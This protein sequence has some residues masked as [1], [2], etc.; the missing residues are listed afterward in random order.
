MNDLE[1]GLRIELR[2][3]KYGYIKKNQEKRKKIKEN[4]AKLSNDINALD[5]MIASIIDSYSSSETKDEM[6]AKYRKQREVLFSKMKDK[7]MELDSV[8]TLLNDIVKLFK[9]K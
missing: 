5:Y 9:T 6:L 8:P 2:R 4:I 7:I 1:K 3:K